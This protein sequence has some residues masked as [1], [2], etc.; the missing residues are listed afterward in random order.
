MN[1]EAVKTLVHKLAERTWEGGEL[2]GGELQ[3]L[4]LE[5]GI[6]VPVEVAEPCGEN[7]NCADYDCEFPTTCNRLAPEW[8]RTKMEPNQNQKEN[9]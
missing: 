4:L 9:G 5:A 3:D 6:L 8:A 1:I 2:D 7:C